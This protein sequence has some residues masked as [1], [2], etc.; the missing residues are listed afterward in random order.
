M[1]HREAD[2]F[3]LVVFS[4]DFPLLLDDSWADQ[5]VTWTALAILTHF[6]KTKNKV[7]FWTSQFLSLKSITI[8][9]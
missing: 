5:G 2:S 6:S 8:I 1:S 9:Y 3:L 7:N 4:N